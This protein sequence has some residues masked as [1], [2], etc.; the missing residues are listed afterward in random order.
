M[1]ILVNNAGSNPSYGPVVDRD[2]ARVTKTFDVNLWAPILWTSLATR[3]WMAD[4]GGV[5]INTASI[6]GMGFEAGLGGLQRLE[7]SPDSPDQAAGARAVAES[8]G[9][10][11]RTGCGADEA[12]GGG[13]ERA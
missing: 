13:V 7:G 12:G 10:R 2:Y 3:A 8:A 1:D 11:R 5:V 6:G 9:Q 4:H